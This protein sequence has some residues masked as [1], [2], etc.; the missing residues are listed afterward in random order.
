MVASVDYESYRPESSH[1]WMAEDFEPDWVTVIVTSYQ[2]EN[3]ILATLNSVL[4]QSYR[5]IELVLIDDG[6]T[7]NTWAEI[8]KWEAGLPDDDL[9]RVVTYRQENRG[10]PNARNRALQMCKGEFIQEIGSDDLIHPQKLEV[11]VELLRQHDSAQSVWSPMVHFTNDE[12]SSLVSP[13]AKNSYVESAIIRNRVD[14]VFVPQ[15][16]PSAAIHRREVFYRTGPWCEELKRWQDLEY[17]SRM[18]CH[19][20]AWV[21]LPWTPYY[22]RQ[23]DGPRINN[24]YGKKSGILRGLDSITRVESNLVSMGVS[25]NSSW[26]EVSQF[27]LTIALLAIQYDQK[28]E[29]R[30]SIDGAVRTRGEVTFGVKAMFLKA[31]YSLLGSDITL[32]LVAPYLPKAGR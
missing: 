10:A 22:F 30:Q 2:R 26:L 23:H 3:Y 15:Y 20:Q 1:D 28:D 4:N 19:V 5:P 9:F 7:D 24:Q 6:S 18:F 16:L 21:E 27:Y 25:E 11:A 13:G 31:V 32:R 8:E 14:E 17:Q 12:E 29:F